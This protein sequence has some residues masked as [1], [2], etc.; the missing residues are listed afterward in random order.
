ML[1]FFNI[2]KLIIC[3]L[4]YDS[5][6]PQ[7]HVIYSRKKSS[8]ETQ[9]T[10]TDVVNT[11]SQTKKWFTTNTFPEYSHISRMLKDNFMQKC[12]ETTSCFWALHP[13]FPQPLVTTNPLSVSRAYLFWM[14]YINGII[15]YV[16][17]SV[18]EHNVSE[19]LPCVSCVDHLFL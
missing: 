6:R 1:S 13:F 18:L 4:L 15:Q 12:K 8:V 2:K 5:P 17:F 3:I 19:V 9:S 16:V 10:D 11:Q 14:I 7:G